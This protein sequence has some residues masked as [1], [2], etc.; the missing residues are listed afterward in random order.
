LKSIV[1][2]KKKECPL[3]P[4]DTVALVKYREG[5]SPKSAHVESTAKSGENEKV[6]KKN[7][8]N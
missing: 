7:L 6:E 1:G 4:D 2:D 3:R 5:Q 8:E